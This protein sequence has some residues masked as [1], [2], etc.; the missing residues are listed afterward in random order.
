MLVGAEKQDR[1]AKQPPLDAALDG[2]ARVAELGDLARGAGGVVGDR[3]GLRPTYLIYASLIVAF[4]AVSRVR[5]AGLTRFDAPS[6]AARTTVL[7][8]G[9]A[10]S[11][12]SDA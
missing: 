12:A 3:I 8:S 6:L 2:D 1:G 5:Y 7:E 10:R 11:G 9:A 4:I